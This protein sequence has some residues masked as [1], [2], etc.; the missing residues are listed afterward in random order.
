LCFKHFRRS[1]YVLEYYNN[2][3][4]IKERLNGSQEDEEKDAEEKVENPPP[5]YSP[6]FYDSDSDDE[7]HIPNDI[8]I[9]NN[10]KDDEEYGLDMFYDKA[11]D[12]PHYS[13]IIHVAWADKIISS[14]D[15]NLYD[16]NLSVG[17]SIG[18]TNLFQKED[19]KNLSLGMS[20]HPQEVESDEENEEYAEK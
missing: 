1:S 19:D 11:L 16:D 15:D 17:G 10:F 4:S 6:C 13:T 20:M 18:S 5:P 8:I 9:D 3:V 7:Q 2:L 12:D 14:C